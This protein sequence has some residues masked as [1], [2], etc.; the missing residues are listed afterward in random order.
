MTVEGLTKQ[1]IVE[2]DFFKDTG[3][4]A[5]GGTPEPGTHG[6]FEPATVIPVDKDN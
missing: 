3:A 2:D 5:S 1:A 6:G 4:F